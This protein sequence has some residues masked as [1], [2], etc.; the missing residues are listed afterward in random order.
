MRL[1][2]PIS[3]SDASGRRKCCATRFRAVVFNSE[4]LRI[5]C[6]INSPALRSNT[7]ASR[8]ALWLS[9]SAHLICSDRPD[10]IQITTACDAG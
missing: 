8:C 7:H 6:R 5:F 3:A 1:A 2:P 10:V 4:R 9:G